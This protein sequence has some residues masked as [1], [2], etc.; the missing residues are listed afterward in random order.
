[1]HPAWAARLSRVQAQYSK[2]PRVARQVPVSHASQPYEAFPPRGPP[3]PAPAAEPYREPQGPQSTQFA[4]AYPEDSMKQANRPI[5]L[6]PGAQVD[7]QIN[8]VPGAQV[9]GETAPSRVRMRSEPDL[10]VWLQFGLRF[11]MGL[12]EKARATRADAGRFARNYGALSAYSAPHIATLEARLQRL[13]SDLWI[14]DGEISACFSQR[15]L[16]S[17][18]PQ[19]LQTVRPLEHNLMRVLLGAL[20]EDSAAYNDVVGESRN[21]AA[22]LMLRQDTAQALPILI[23]VYRDR[24]ERRPVGIAAEEYDE[25]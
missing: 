8:L 9:L 19:F 14:I 23:A 17:L 25:L 1:M 10:R 20:R 4:L 22:H 3:Q 16:S 24:Q 7:R 2:T 12:N 6:V 13:V 18:R 11:L 15:E 5:H 21:F